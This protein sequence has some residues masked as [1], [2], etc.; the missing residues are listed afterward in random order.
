MINMECS[1]RSGFADHRAYQTCPDKKP[2]AQKNVEDRGR[3]ERGHR[4]LAAGTEREQEKC[5][6]PRGARIHV[7]LLLQKYMRLKIFKKRYLIHAGNRLGIGFKNRLLPPPALK[8]LRE[9]VGFKIKNPR[10]IRRCLESSGPE[11]RR[12][13]LFNY[14]RYSA[15]V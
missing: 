11:P 13:H 2:K 9:V 4:T 15:R 14:L 10:P 8:A 6:M 5:L 1:L 7:S 12:S 3:G